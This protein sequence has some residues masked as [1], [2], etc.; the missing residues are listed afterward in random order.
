[1]RV[2]QEYW[3]P[4]RLQNDDD[5]LPARHPLRLAYDIAG[6]FVPA[7][8]LL[9]LTAVFVLKPVTVFGVSMMPTLRDR[10]RV[11]VTSFPAPLRHGDIVVVSDAGTRMPKAQPIIKRVIGL[12]GDVIDID[13]EACLVIRNGIAL[14]EPYIAEPTSRRDDFIGPVTVQDG[15]VFLMGDNRNHS[16]D[17]R[18][19]D[20]ALVDQRYIIGRVLFI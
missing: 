4:L 3:V 18:S 8:V 6:T 13:F 16:T 10:Q 19:N 17:S 5:P 11:A 1:M 14:D 15:K 9:V 12:P 20:V 7:V 2:E